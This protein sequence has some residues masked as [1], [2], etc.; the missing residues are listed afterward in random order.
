MSAFDRVREAGVA[1]ASPVDLLAVGLARR[2]ED[3]DDAIAREVLQD[4]GGIVRLAEL[5]N[6]S[7]RDKAGLTTFEAIRVQALIELG[8]RSHGA[9]KGLRPSIESPEDIAEMFD[10]LRAEKREHFVA[11]YLDSKAYVLRAVTIHIGTVN[12]SLVGPREVFR[13]AVR[14]G[15]VSL[16][17]AHNH[18]SGDPT[19]SPEDIN[20]TKRLKEVGD[21]LDIRLLDHVIL[22]DRRFVS[23]RNMGVIQ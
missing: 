18:P 11:V 21:V 8:R 4:L 6:E 19:P 23:L 2:D 13:E 12:A 22:G 7:L 3:V 16:I 17:V 20:V 10:H 1:G 14:E 15:A 5:S 9:G